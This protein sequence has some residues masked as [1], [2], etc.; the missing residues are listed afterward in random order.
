M[1]FT[2]ILV[3]VVFFAG[4]AF[5][6]DY[7]YVRAEARAAVRSLLEEY[8]EIQA[9][10]QCVVTGNECVGNV[11]KACGVLCNGSPCAFNVKYPNKE[12]L[13]ICMSKCHCGGSAKT[14]GAAATVKGAKTI[15]T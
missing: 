2:S 7:N 3:S 6:A 12:V 10:D 13:N 1:K 15:K 14:G 8:E 11:E 5:A 4:A 9:R